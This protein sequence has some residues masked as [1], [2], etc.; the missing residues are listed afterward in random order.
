MRFWN[1]WLFGYNNSFGNDD[2]REEQTS[3][4][5]G[6]NIGLSMADIGFDLDERG[7]PAPQYAS[8]TDDAGNG[9]L[10]RLCPIAIFFSGHDPALLMHH[11]RQSSFATHPGPVAAEACAVHAWLV[12]C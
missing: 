10:M 6:G 9:S 5:L 8:D 3:V 12:A 1:W 11:A 2:D 7:L 4:G